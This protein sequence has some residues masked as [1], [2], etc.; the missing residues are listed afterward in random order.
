MTIKYNSNLD[1]ETAGGAALPGW[2][3]IGG[4]YSVRVASAISRV[5]ISGANVYAAS[6]DADTSLYTAGGVLTDQAIRTAIRVPALDA[7]NYCASGHIL[8]SSV[9]SDVDVSQYYVSPETNGTAIRLSI[10]SRSVGA[11]SVL[12]SSGYTLSPSPTDTVHFESKAVGNVIESRMWLN[13]D[14]RP[15]APTVTATNSVVGSGY[16]GVRHKGAF[17]WDVVDNIVVTDGAGGEDYFYPAA[18]GTTITCT[19]GSAS[20]SGAS[21]S[22]QGSVTIAASVGSASAA[23]SAATIT[24]SIPSTTVACAV[25]N[26]AAAGLTAAFGTFIQSDR[27]INNTG[28]LL[29]AQ[30]VV[31]TW[32]PAGRTGSMVG[33]TPVDGTGTTDANARLAPGIARAAGKLDIAVRAAA[34][35]DDALYT[36]MFA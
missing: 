36:E 28:T 34:A 23:G 6:S 10:I 11:A 8:R 22:I 24:N 29:P 5:A 30:A 17:A 35:V 16:A 12:S 21:A 1:A 31:W 33:I 25:G 3:A 18:T 20:A 9:A 32:T 7:T 15:A 4:G 13:S 2:A 19:V 14:P 26:A 27:L